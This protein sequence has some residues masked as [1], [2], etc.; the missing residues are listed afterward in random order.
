[1]YLTTPHPMQRYWDILSA[2]VQATALEYALQHGIL[3][4]LQQ[5][6]TSEQLA[7]KLML[8]PQATARL[9]E[10][11]WSM[12]LLDRRPQTSCTT[13]AQVQYVLSSTAHTYLLDDTEHNCSQAWLFRAKTLHQ[14]SKT[15]IAALEGRL[16]GNHFAA[17]QPEQAWA[18]AARE[19]IAQEQRT[20][21]APAVIQL[22]REKIAVPSQG[23]FLDLG[24]GPGFISIELARQ[25]PELTG[26]IFDLP[27]TAEVADSNIRAA[28]LQER[29]CSRG[30][31]A[32]SD[33]L[34][35]PYDMIWCSSVLH[36]LPDLDTALCKITAALKPEG[37]LICAHAEISDTA[38][39]ALRILPFYLP[40]MLRGHYV[41]HRDELPCAFRRHGLVLLDSHQ[42]LHSPMA[43]IW[44]HTGKKQ[45]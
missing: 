16:A 3:A 34:G 19:Q 13:P 9:L 30:G 20:I 35:G 38:A 36:F 7:R 41:P 33:D 25:Y 17:V 21:T 15:L 2:N 31:N 6:L 40:L 28:G 10:L 44:I 32:I 37:L 39:E 27:A 4:K 43:P 11:L 1:M 42:L 29:L 23:R 18:N 26:T 5:P 8:E 22:L 12:E 24:G 45:I 14:S